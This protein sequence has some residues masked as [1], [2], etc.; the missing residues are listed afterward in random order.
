M[1]HENQ[2]GKDI[3]RILIE[4]ENL[5]KEINNLRNKIC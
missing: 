5:K 4:N 2:Q 3:H 1:S